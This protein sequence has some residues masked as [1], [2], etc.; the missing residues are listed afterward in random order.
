MKAEEYRSG[1]TRHNTAAGFPSPGVHFG[2]NW[3]YPPKQVSLMTDQQS[4]RE[5]WQNA[6]NDMMVRVR[7]AIE[8]AEESTLPALQHLVHK[9]R[10][11]AIE[12]GELTRDEAEKVAF[13]LQRD[14]QDAGHHLAETGHELGD[15]LRFDVDLIE[16]R[17]LDALSLVADHTRLEMLQF[18]QELQAGPAW[19]SGEY[20]GPGTLLCDR[21]GNPL[22]FHATGEIPPCPNCGHTV[23]HRQQHHK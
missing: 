12:L 13:Y 18:E 11:T 10:D 6:Y 20:C 7:T 23:Y 4:N 14:L 21:C 3:K 16:E 15:W 8:E 9:A 5:K 17:L 1:N 22:R 19:N 2:P